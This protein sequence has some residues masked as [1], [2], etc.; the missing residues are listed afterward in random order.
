[1]HVV[2]NG[3]AARAGGWSADQQRDAGGAVRPR[4][5]SLLDREEAVA[6]EAGPRADVR[7][8]LADGVHEAHDVQAQDGR[9]LPL[10]DAV[11]G[12][13]VVE[14]LAL[15]GFPPQGRP[16]TRPSSRAVSSA[17]KARFGPSAASS[18][19]ARYRK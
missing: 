2:Q 19:V 3:P 7:H 16:A 1:M 15:F 10:R 17:S 12:T 18:F 13:L 14:P 9:P 8:V 5:P 6:A 11:R 4:H